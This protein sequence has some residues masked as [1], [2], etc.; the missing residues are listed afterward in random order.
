[1][2]T[3]VLVYKNLQNWVI[4]DKGKCWCAYSSTR[5]R[6]WD[7][8]PCG[9]RL[10]ELWSTCAHYRALARKRSPWKSDEITMKSPLNPIKSPWNPVKSMDILGLSP[11]CD[12]P[13]GMVDHCHSDITPSFT[14]WLLNRARGMGEVY[15]ILDFIFKAC[16]QIQFNTDL[17]LASCQE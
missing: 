12:K 2:R 14:K 1:M 5:V 9:T 13:L 8:K 17:I 6:I 10:D 4:L 16:D 7:M 11:I 3:M 15:R